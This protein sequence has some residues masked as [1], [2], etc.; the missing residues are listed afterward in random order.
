[1]K[2]KSAMIRIFFALLLLLLISACGG[3]SYRSNNDI[4]GTWVS[5]ETTQRI[6]IYFTGDEIG[7]RSWDSVDGENFI[8]RD[9]KWDGKE[10]KATFVMPSTGHTTHSIIRQVSSDSLEETYEGDASGKMIWLRE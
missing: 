3:L 6:N 2:R 9:L 7:V 5:S 8:I 4:A 1:M 10:L